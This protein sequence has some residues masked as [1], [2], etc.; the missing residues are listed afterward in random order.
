[1]MTAAHGLREILDI[2]ELTALRGVGEV[3]SKLAQLARGRGIAT[4][5]GSLGGALQVSSDLLRNLCVLSRIR[6]LKLLQRVQQLGEGR[7]LAIVLRSRGGRGTEAARAG[8]GCLAGQADTLQSCAES[9][10]KKGGGE[11]YGSHEDSI[12][13][14]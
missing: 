10:L 5:C 1:M 9:G 4:R 12:G 7:K 14:F 11:A 3:R 2:G 13:S 8:W 6:L